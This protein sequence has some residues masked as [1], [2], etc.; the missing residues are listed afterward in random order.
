M[1]EF[2]SDY[3]GSIQF[4]EVSGSRI[5]AGRGFGDVERRFRQ[6]IG[7]AGRPG[8]TN[9]GGGQDEKAL[10]GEIRD[11]MRDLTNRQFRARAG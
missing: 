1:R 11:A 2:R 6:A 3:Y 9:R 8:R 7:D 4:E 10:L 5:A